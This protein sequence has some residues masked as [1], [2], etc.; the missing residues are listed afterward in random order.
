MSV[1]SPPTRQNT[2]FAPRKHPKTRYENRKTADRTTLSPE[3][4]QQDGPGPA[5][6]AGLRSNFTTSSKPASSRQETLKMMRRGSWANHPDKARQLS[7]FLARQPEGSPDRKEFYGLFSPQRMN[8]IMGLKN[9]MKSLDALSGQFKNQHVQALGNRLSDRNFSSK[10]RSLLTSVANQKDHPQQKLASRFLLDDKKSMVQADLKTK[11]SIAELGG[12]LREKLLDQHRSPVTRDIEKRTATRFLDGLK[13][14]R[15]E[16]EAERFRWQRYRNGAEMMRSYRP[17]DET[18]HK[19]DKN[20]ARLDKAGIDTKALERY[21]DLTRASVLA[22]SPKWK[23][24]INAD[25]LKTELEK[26]LQDPRV[27][28]AL[29][30]AH[31][32]ALNSYS[33]ADRKRLSAEQLAYLGGQK[34]RDRLQVLAKDG[35]SG[36]ALRQELSNLVKI[37]P[38]GTADQA[39]AQGVKKLIQGLDPSERSKMEKALQTYQSEHPGKLTSGEQKGLRQWLLSQTPGQ[40][41][42]ADKLGKAPG[43]SKMIAKNPK[44]LSKLLGAT[45]LFGNAFSATTSLLGGAADLSKGNTVAGSLALGSGLHTLSSGVARG[46]AQRLAGKAGLRALAG[47]ALGSFFHPAVGVALTVGSLAFAPDQ[48]RQLLERLQLLR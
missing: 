33:E 10:A 18:R 4:R 23:D 16:L 21:R 22:H 1:I 20:L 30:H 47:R 32:Q 8:N 28:S 35:K 9:G 13:K 31:R 38:K 29:Q 25:K 24:K 19:A 3:S 44:L 48:N 5:L 6:L 11:K 14:G 26:S 27:G 46:V 12:P 41:A 36:D 45:S 40:L 2:H 43:I 34:F 39:Y 15:S 37:S 42:H 17:A 7:N